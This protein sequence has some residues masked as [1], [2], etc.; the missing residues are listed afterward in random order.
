MTLKMLRTTEKHIVIFS[1]NYFI[2]ICL[3]T[4]YPN[5]CTLFKSQSVIEKY[6]GHI[7]RKDWEK[8]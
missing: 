5:I 6:L 7:V 8:F 3:E 2:N 1:L 4:I